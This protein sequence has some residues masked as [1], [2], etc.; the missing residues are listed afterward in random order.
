MVAKALDVWIET[1]RLCGIEYLDGLSRIRA[2]AMGEPG[3][4]CHGDNW[5]GDILEPILPTTRDKVSADLL[6]PRVWEAIGA[7]A[8]EHLGRL[9]LLTSPAP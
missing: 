1:L 4:G 2:D 8:R 5:R 3:R 6:L 7:A 9:S